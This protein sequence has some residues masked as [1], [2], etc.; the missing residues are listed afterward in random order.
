M[1]SLARRTGSERSGFF[2]TEATIWQSPR[3]FGWET[4]RAGSK[5]S[6]RQSSSFP[7]HHR[8]LLDGTTAPS[9][10]KTIITVSSIV[11]ATAHPRARDAP[12]PRVR[13]VS[14]S[15][16]QPYRLISARPRSIE[17]FDRPRATSVATSVHVPRARATRSFVSTS[18]SARLL[19]STPSL[20]SSLARVTARLA[21]RSP[22][23]ARPRATS[24]HPSID[25]TG[26]AR[27]GRR[28]PIH[29]TTAGRIKNT[30][31][32]SIDPNAR[33]PRPH[34]STRRLSSSSCARARSRRCHARASN[35]YR[36][37]AKPLTAPNCARATPVAARRAVVAALAETTTRDGAAIVVIITATREGS[38]EDVPSRDRRARAHRVSIDRWM[39][40]RKTT[41][42]TTCGR[43]RG[44]YI[45]SAGHD[46]W[47]R[48]GGG[49]GQRCHES[50]LVTRDG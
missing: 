28:R 17:P 8:S 2:V 9:T 1:A 31:V 20:V 43:A 35:T 10:Q 49:G 21:G 32:A 12:S 44:F 22:P 18:T 29:E 11:H 13:P 33:S 27:E 30:P 5:F 25:S 50:R 6:K 38:R 42:T 15:L 40:G 41:R 23:R 39:D 48:G 4:L 19:S 34:R 24:S 37:G 7:S 45:E 14:P 3:V 26:D 47:A 36:D 46:S 16:L